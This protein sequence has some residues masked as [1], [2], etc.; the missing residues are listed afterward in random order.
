MVRKLFPFVVA[1]EARM[2]ALE[3]NLQT[4]S[5]PAAANHAEFN[6]LADL[7]SGSNLVA[8]ILLGIVVTYYVRGRKN[9]GT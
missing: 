3:Q 8:A 7:T 6:M 5:A 2:A 9:H 4:K 1:L